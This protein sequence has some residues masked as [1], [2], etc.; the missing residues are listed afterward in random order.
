MSHFPD[1]VDPPDSVKAARKER[2]H[3]LSWAIRW[4]VALRMSIIVCEF[5]GFLVTGSN[6]L[7]LDGFASLFDVFSSLFLLLFVRLA[8]K[9]PDSEHPFGH[10]RYEPLAGLQ[11]GLLLVVFGAGMCIQQAFEIAIPASGVV[12][13][14]AWLISFGALLVLELCFAIT[15]RVA[16]KYESSA[17]AAD[18]AHYRIDSLTSFLATLTLLLA[19]YFPEWSQRIDHAGAIL[20]GLFMIGM[21]IYNARENLQQLLDRAPSADCFERVKKAAVNVLGV[22]DTEKILIQHYGPDAHV[23][24][25]IEVDPKLSVEEAHRIT[26]HVRA[27]IQREW[28]AVRGVTVHVEPYYPGDH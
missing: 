8:E 16:K 5:V 2:Q 22:K 14:W 3:N 9:P 28:P 26:Q 25:D 19:A 1:S 4:G 24:I 21:G 7:L 12:T 6:A 10:G 23:N 17:L 18:A 11:L 15:M 20:I 13:S 27:E